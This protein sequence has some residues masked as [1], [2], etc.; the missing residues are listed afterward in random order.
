MGKML[1][2]KEVHTQL[3][4]DMGETGASSSRMM[5]LDIRGYERKGEPG[6]E[7][8]ETRQEV[9]V[10]EALEWLIFESFEINNIF[11]LNIRFLVP[12]P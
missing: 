12:H 6:E 4:E 11:F 7:E 8:R 3:R 2:L 1:P 9:A 5:R 10:G